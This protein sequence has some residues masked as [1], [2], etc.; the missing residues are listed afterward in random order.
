MK[1]Y[2][3]YIKSN[4]HPRTINTPMMARTYYTK[5]SVQGLEALQAKCE[6]LVKNGETINEIRIERGPKLFFINGK[7]VK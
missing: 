2:N 7:I 4:E 6:E 1:N 3:I 5:I